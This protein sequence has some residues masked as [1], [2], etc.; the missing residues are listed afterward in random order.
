MDVR[1]ANYQSLRMRFY[2]ND[3]VR[4]AVDEL[5]KR[6]VRKSDPALKRLLRDHIT[7]PIEQTEETWLRDSF[8]FLIAHYSMLEIAAIGGSIGD[9]EEEDRRAAREQLEQP[10]VERYYTETYP[11]LLPILFRERL[12]GRI[13]LR[14]ASSSGE[15]R[16]K[17]RTLVMRFTQFIGARN[18]DRDIDRFLWLMDD[19]IVND[20]GWTDLLGPLADLDAFVRVTG[21]ELR[22]EEEGDVQA[23]ALRGFMKFIAFCEQLQRLLE[24][25]DP[26]PLLQ[27]AMWHYN[28]YWFVRIADKLGPRLETALDTV[29]TWRERCENP[30]AFDRRWRESRDHVGQTMSSVMS[31]KYA[32]A[33]LE[34]GGF[35]LIEARHPRDGRVLLWSYRQRPRTAVEGTEDLEAGD[36]EFSA[37]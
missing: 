29:S 32:H 28:A 36:A 1:T 14:E 6:S 5:K 35:D 7:S 19:G 17:A 13:A 20:V 26:L 34:A 15:E 27:S 11:Q 23:Q 16:R 37:E 22:E 12:A 4:R 24:A 3:H 18:A 21:K 25:A 9:L 31:R 30:A 10:D 8:D 33:L 2:D